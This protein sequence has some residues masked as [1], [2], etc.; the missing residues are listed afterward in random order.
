MNISIKQL[1]CIQTSIWIIFGILWYIIPS[2]LLSYNTIK[3]SYDSLHIHLTKVFGL[4]LIFIGSMFFNLYNKYNNK[5]NNNIN[6]N[7]NND[8][9]N[10]IK[11]YCKIILIF[12]GLLLLTQLYD[13]FNSTILNYNHLWGIIGLIISMIFPLFILHKID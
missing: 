8:I 2:T 4:C 6:N 1:L 9:N 13:N 3:M 10:D 5:Y 12:T 11:F 7:I